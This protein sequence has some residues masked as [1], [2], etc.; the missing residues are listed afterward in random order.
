MLIES[1]AGLEMK[2]LTFT[3]RKA[4]AILASSSFFFSRRPSKNIRQK[5]IYTFFLMFMKEICLEA[6]LLEGL[7][8][9]KW[10]AFQEGD[11][12]SKKI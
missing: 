12:F 1:F 11:G 8:K 3:V 4:A 2:P 6:C 10:S 5:P 7:G 9:S